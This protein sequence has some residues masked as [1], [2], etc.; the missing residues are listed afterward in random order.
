MGKIV[1][2]LKNELI[3]LD[4]RKRLGWKM[5]VTTGFGQNSIM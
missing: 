3:M 4:F 5:K 2:E 1:D